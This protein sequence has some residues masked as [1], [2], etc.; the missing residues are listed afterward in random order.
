MGDRLHEII[1]IIAQDAADEKLEQTAQTALSE[2]D[3]EIR[4]LQHQASLIRSL[5]AHYKPDSAPAVNETSSPVPTFG[6]DTSTGPQR[7]ALIYDAA[8]AVT[9]GLDTIHVR[10]VTEELI[11]RGYVFSRSNQRVGTV[12]QF[13]PTEFRP[14]FGGYWKVLWWQ[15]EG[16]TDQ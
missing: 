14:M 8:L 1:A 4:R 11:R 13:H 6:A 2:I 16:R 5:L 9:R 10:D 3:A 15:Q 12:L 7:H